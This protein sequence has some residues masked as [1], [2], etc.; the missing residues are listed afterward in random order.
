MLMC[1]CNKE[2]LNSRQNTTKPNQKKKDEKYCENVMPTTPDDG[3]VEV[4]RERAAVAAF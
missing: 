4:E 2:R 1:G 3:D